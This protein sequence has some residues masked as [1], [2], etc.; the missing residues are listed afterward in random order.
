MAAPSGNAAASVASAT[1]TAEARVAF[2]C[3]PDFAL[4]KNVRLPGPACSS[5]MMRR[6]STSPAPSR[7]HSI[8]RAMSASFNAG[9]IPI[10]SHCVA[11]C[12]KN[13]AKCSSRRASA[14][15]WTFS[16]RVSGASE[17]IARSDVRSALP[18]ALQ[19]TP[20]RPWRA[21]RSER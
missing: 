16:S 11:Y 9:S 18:S 20:T 19:V 5:P 8:C 6:M 10:G 7:R 14:T 13:L 2:N 3:A 15:A 12:W 21:P 4:A 17:T 1:I